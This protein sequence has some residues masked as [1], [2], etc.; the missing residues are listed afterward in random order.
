MSVIN[1]A[2]GAQAFEV[3][4]ERVGE[5]LADELDMQFQLT[6]DALMEATVYIERHVPFNQSE[7][8]A[9]NVQLARVP[10][11]NHDQLNTDGSQIFFID[12]ITKA[13]AAANVDGDSYSARLMQRLMGVCRAILEDSKYKTLGFSP[14]FIMNRRVMDMRFGDP[15]TKDSVS[16]AKG[17]IILQVRAAEIN[18]IVV[19]NV[20]DSYKTSI[21]LHESEAGYFYFG[22]TYP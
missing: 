19:P 4:R 7:L 13:N 1:Q 21:K 11:D 17:R 22:E 16:V 15:Q 14:P 20:I 9:V 12:C 18:G 6:Y 5:I 10:L 2:I 3:I 8:P